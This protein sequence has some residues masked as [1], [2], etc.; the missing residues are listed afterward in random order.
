MCYEVAMALYYQ[1]ACYIP[2]SMTTTNDTRF[3]RTIHLK[4]LD[5]PLLRYTLTQCSIHILCRLHYEHVGGY[6]IFIKAVQ[7]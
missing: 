4:F 2:V 5:Q 6:S 1:S 3:Q 7:C